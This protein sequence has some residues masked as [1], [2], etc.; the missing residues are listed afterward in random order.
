[1]VAC[2]LHTNHPLFSITGFLCARKM[3]A[4]RQS[5][6]LSLSLSF[7]AYNRSFPCMESYH[8]I[9]THWKALKAPQLGHFTSLEVCCY[10]IDLGASIVMLNQSEH[11]ISTISTNESA[12][13]WFQVEALVI[14]ETPVIGLI[15]N[16]TDPWPRCSCVSFTITT[17]VKI[18]T[19][20][21]NWN[22]SFYDRGT[23]ISP[24]L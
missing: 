19:L 10:G 23:I 6:A 21:R 18:L 16:G 11:S 24:L 9:T 14:A 5:G 8:A 17:K 13:L 15:P 22:Q 7:A 3:S 20:L 4:S 1:M 12:P 2:N